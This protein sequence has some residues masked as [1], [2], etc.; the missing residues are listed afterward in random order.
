MSPTHQIQQPQQPNQ[1]LHKFPSGK[2][3]MDFDEFI[4][5]IKDAC[6][7]QES[8]ENYLVLAFSM[9]DVEK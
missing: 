7:D 3:T 1:H 5:V 2:Q 8:A 6:M 4:D 9:F